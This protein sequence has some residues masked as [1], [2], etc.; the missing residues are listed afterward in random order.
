MVSAVVYVHPACQCMCVI[1]TCK[2]LVSQMVLNFV[3][4]NIFL[5]V[6]AFIHQRLFMML[7]VFLIK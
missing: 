5:K 7:L 4:D 3:Q 6:F 1:I 2:V